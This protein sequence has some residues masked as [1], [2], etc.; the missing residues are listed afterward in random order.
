MKSFEI[1]EG[2][3]R[4]DL[5]NLLEKDNLIGIELG[6]AGG[7]FSKKMIETGKFK[8]FFGVD[9]YSDHHDLNQYKSAIKYVG[10]LENYNLLKLDF[11]QD[12]EMFDDQFFD[13]IYID[14]YAHN[15]QKGGETLCKWIKK[16]KPGGIFCGDDYD[17]KFPLT[18]EAVNYISK[19]TNLNFYITDIRSETDHNYASWAFKIDKFYNIKIKKDLRFKSKVYDIY[20]K[21]KIKLKK[22]FYK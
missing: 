17:Q 5:V 4:Y 16:V 12:L 3:N 19:E 6:V 13:F 2:K 8:F 10:I 22:F 9:K 1:L 18:I 15:G 20:Y 11:N 14:G 7:L 21:C